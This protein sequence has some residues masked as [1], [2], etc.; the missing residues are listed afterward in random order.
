MLKN[1]AQRVVFPILDAD[2]DPVTGAASD[3]PDSEYSLD[4]ASFADCSDEIHEIATSSGI[5]YLDLLAA[6]TNG[7]V[8][9]VQIKT[10][11]ATT[12]TTVLVFYTS[13]QSLDTIDT[14]VDSILTDTG[15]TLDGKIDTIDGVVDAILVDTNE[16]QGKLPSKAYLTG[17]TDADGGIDA[18]EAAIINAQVLDVMNTDTFAEPSSVPA[19]TASLVDKIAWICALARNKITQTATTQTLRNDADDGNIGTSTVS[20]DGTTATRGEFS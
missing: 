20:D 14:N 4:G 1:S 13:S 5:Y 7:D 10:A 3:T 19:A 15:T 12:K 8:V 11:A 6:E 18:T 2:G 17:S 9:A 16:V